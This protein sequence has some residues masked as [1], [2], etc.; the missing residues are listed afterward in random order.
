MG[1]CVRHADIQ[2]LPT[3][4]TSTPSILKN[5]NMSPVELITN[6]DH[7]VAAIGE[8][9]QDKEII[10]IVDFT[11]SWCGPCKVISPTFEELA[12]Q[13]TVDKVKF[14]KVD[15][16]QVPDAASKAGI[17]A[18]PTFLVYKNGQVIDTLRG[19][20]KEPLKTL[21]AKASL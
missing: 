5:L 8:N 1:G 7:F 6:L 2:K 21:V 19:A 17:S 13:N 20:A 9:V 4:P 12:S 16:D 18:M 11:A 10:A 15:V 3:N 14:Y